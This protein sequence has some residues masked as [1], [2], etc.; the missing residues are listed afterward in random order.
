M[1]SDAGIK[2]HDYSI[3][4]VEGKGDKSKQNQGEGFVGLCS[5]MWT[6]T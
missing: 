5:E 2:I 4:L 1:F 6:W 3:H